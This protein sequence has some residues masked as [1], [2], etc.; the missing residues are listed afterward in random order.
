MILA[1]AVIGL[2]ALLIVAGGLV[3]YGVSLFGG[4]EQPNRRATN[5]QMRGDDPLR[6]PLAARFERRQRRRALGLRIAAVGGGIA[7]TPEALE[8]IRTGIPIHQLNGPAVNGW[9]ALAAALF[10]MALGVG[11]I[12]ASWR[13]PPPPKS[14]QE[15]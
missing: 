3:W 1:R 7:L 9:V 14:D 12:M 15:A 6:P 4:A 5:A 11:V 10:V 8:S 2:V 13:T